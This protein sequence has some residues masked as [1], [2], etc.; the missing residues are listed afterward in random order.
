MSYLINS[1]FLDR[2]FNSMI[3]RMNDL[4]DT[5]IKN[6]ETEVTV[7]KLKLEETEDR[8][9]AQERRNIIRIFGVPENASEDTDKLVVDL[10]RNKLNVDLSLNDIDCSHRLKSKVGEHRPIIV[11]LCRRNVKNLIFRAKTRLKGTKTIIREDLTPKRL[12]LVKEA[13]AKVGNRNVFTSNGNIFIKV[14]NI[15]K[16][17]CLND[18]K[19]FT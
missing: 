19:I 11:K 1:G 16:V 5:R 14:N 9:E 7:L 6:Y 12:Q 18:L 3:T 15:Q 8:L 4:I 2:L 13:M 10:C 17:N